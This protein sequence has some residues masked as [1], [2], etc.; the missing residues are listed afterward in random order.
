MSKSESVSLS[1]L[2]VYLQASRGLREPTEFGLVKSSRYMC[3]NVVTVG[4][5]KNSFSPLE[6]RRQKGGL[7]SIRP[8]PGISQLSHLVD[9][10][11]LPMTGAICMHLDCL[12]VLIL[13][14]R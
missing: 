7:P 9:R 8:S 3:L 6:E 12:C 10:I 1:E 4:S 13:D 2:L 11:L 5:L 14:I